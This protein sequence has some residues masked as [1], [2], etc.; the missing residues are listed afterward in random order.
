LTVYLL[1]SIASAFASVECNSEGDAL[2][3][4]KNKLIDPNNV[5]Q[6]W[7]PTLQNPCTWDLGNAGLSGP[8]V[9]ELG[10][11]TNLQ[12]LEVY[13]NHING[14]I[15]REI[16]KLKRLISFG[17]EYNCPSGTIPKSFGHLNSL[18]FLRV[19]GNNLSGEIPAL[20]GNLTSL[21]ILNLSSNKFS[22]RIPI[23]VLS[24]V[25]WGKL[26]TL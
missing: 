16:G 26:R 5:L 25:R 6:S 9:P 3:A 14:T 13:G 12:Y 2:N 21:E 23:E 20:L 18:R 22:G 15:P 4:W 1:L 8:L 24:L 10:N 19:S 11:L 7:D 17:L